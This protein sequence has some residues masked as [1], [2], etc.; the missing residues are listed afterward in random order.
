MNDVE[1]PFICLWWLEL[2]P[3]QNFSLPECDLF[4]EQ[5]LCRWSYSGTIM[6][7]A[8]G[9]ESPMS[10]NSTVTDIVINSDADVCTQGDLHV[11]MKADICKPRN[12]KDGWQNSGRWERRTLD[13]P[14]QPRKEPAL[15]TPGSQPSRLHHGETVHFCFVSPVVGGPLLQQP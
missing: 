1:C 10:V 3:L 8:D 14:S 5:S 11:T 15:P 12:T 6:Q 2:R 4:W 9:G 13:G 7:V